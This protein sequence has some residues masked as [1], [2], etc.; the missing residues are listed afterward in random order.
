[1]KFTS[2]VIF[3][4]LYIVFIV[5]HLN[6][7][8]ILAVKIIPSYSHQIPFRSLWKELHKRGHEIVLIA[9]DTMPDINSTNFRQ[10]STNSVYKQFKKMNY[11]HYRVNNIPWISLV[12]ENICEYGKMFVEH[13]LSNPEVK[14]LY[15]PESKEK[16]DVVLFELHYIPAIHMLA[17]RF[18]APLI[19]LCSF[20][21]PIIDEYLLG[22]FVMPSHLSTWE[23]ENNVGTNLT[24]WKRLENFWTLWHWIYV[25]F[26][27]HMSLQQRIAEEY[28]GK[29]LPSILDFL[30]NISLVFVNQDP[31]MSYARPSLPNVIMFH[32]THISKNV[33]PLPQDLKRFVDNATNGFIYMSFGTNA[34]F[35][36]LPEN[37]QQIFH[38]VF[39][40][41]P[42]K[43]VIKLE[44][45][46]QTYENVYT[47]KWLPQQSI[48]AHPNLKLYIFQGGLQS[49][50]EAIH[51][52]V[53]LL[54]FPILSDQNYQ[55]RL[56]ESHG[57][58]RSMDILNLS[59]EKLE[60]TI[61]DIINDK[62]YKENMIKLRIRVNDT[63]YD[64]LQ[65]LVWWTEYVI[66]NRGAPQFNNS[67]AW[68]PWY[69]YCDMDIVVFLS[70]VTFIVTLIMLII[71]VKLLI[72]IFKR[73]SNAS[74]TN[75]KKKKS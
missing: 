12:K 9:P 66:R 8:R 67:L 40:K 63:P 43:I 18:N 49:T 44:N 51:Y 19:G 62:R 54:G 75:L 74:A 13:I 11:V 68:Q 53:P 32:S 57:V 10:I 58:G 17:H 20:G 7:A 41:L 27:D 36:Y 60:S 47:A 61:R 30:K 71:S 56:I 46:S 16:F 39:A 69:Q 4:V 29:P 33:E 23:M 45:V 73:W 37:I 3:S 24:F 38:D 55:L 52:G 50:Q 5:K 2:V 72:C 42:Y 59:R 6:G 34:K 48:L 21:I 1:M 65:N 64:L 31:I 26:R 35:T 14:E 15:A 28:F 22:G 25:T 70:I